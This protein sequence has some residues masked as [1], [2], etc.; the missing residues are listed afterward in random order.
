M[1]GVVL[2]ASQLAAEHAE[3]TLDML[4]AERLQNQYILV[5][6]LPSNTHYMLLC[7]SQHRFAVACCYANTSTSCQCKPQ[8]S[9]HFFC[10]SAPSRMQVRAGESA[11]DAAGIGYSNPVN[12]QSRYSELT[13]LGKQQV[14]KRLVPGLLPFVQNSSAWVWSCINT[15]SYQ[16]AEIVCSAV[17]LTQNR[18]VPEYS[19]L[20]PRCS[21]PSGIQPLDCTNLF[22]VSIANLG[23]L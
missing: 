2:G 15:C 8:V 7:C 1:G 20:D 21:P 17:G 5:R 10:T 12:K 6:V 22:F 16:T 13:T 19:F 18:L 14:V 3:A 11:A 23:S 4:P 9:I